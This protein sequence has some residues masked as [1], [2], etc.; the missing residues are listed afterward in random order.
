MEKKHESVLLA[1]VIGWLQ[2]GPGKVLLDGT[3][4]LGGHSQRWLELSGPDGKVVGFDRDPQAVLEARRVL[5]VFGDRALIINKNY[6]DAFETLD[7]M[8]IPA[9]DAVLL[10]LGVS[11]MQ[12]DEASRGFS[13]KANGP[14]DMR[15][16]PQEGLDAKDLVNEA[17]EKQLADIFWKYGEE[18]MSRRIAKRIVEVRKTK[19]IETTG[20]LESLVFHSVPPGARHGRIHPATRVFQALRIAVNMELEA[21]QVFMDQVAD[22]VLP[23]GRVGVISFHSLEDRIVKNSFKKL[24]AD[25]AGRILTKKPVMASDDEQAANPRS[26]SA[27]M[28]VFEK[29]AEEGRL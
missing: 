6:R 10:D 14:L 21:L 2:P 8:G 17:D 26:R 28:R 22:H 13:F 19:K 1:E 20:D 25:G 3:I 24:Q 16:N 15:M 9:V 4:G 12:L 23:G 7:D 11:S 5:Q 29:N 18:R 27:K